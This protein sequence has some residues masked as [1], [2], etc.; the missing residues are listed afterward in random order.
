MKRIGILGGTFNPIHLGHLAIAEEAKEKL[1]LDQVLFIPC[2]LPPH[3]T[4][5]G[6]AK[7]QNR[8]QMVKLAIK[9][10]KSFV[11][12]DYE[13]KKKGK[14]YSIDTIKYLKDKY[15]DETRFYFIIGADTALTLHSWKKIKELKKL[16]T[17]VAV[18]RLG[19]NE[20]KPKIKVKAINMVN[21][22]I[23]SS[24]IRNCILSK[25]SV[26][27]LVPNEVIKYISQKKLY[28]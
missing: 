4:M 24:Y 25:K 20:A 15:P 10:N 8:L 22:E 11:L 6:L 1:G 21:L 14:S 16:V 23:S 7:A 19:Y 18:N 17:F 2:N 12:C 26:R 9:D 27:Y 28:N 5:P 13:I 3:K